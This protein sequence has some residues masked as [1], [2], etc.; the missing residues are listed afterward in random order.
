MALPLFQNTVLKKYYKN[1]DDYLILEKWIL[2][3]KHF[4]NPDIQKN[5]KKA[6]EEQYQEG[7]LRDLF[8]NILGY[9]LNPAIDFNLTTEHKN[10]RNGRK[11]D[12]AIIIDTKIIGVI[13]LKGTNVT[14]LDKIENQA[15][16]YKNNQED[17][18]YVI[19]SNFQKIRLYIDDAV[20]YIEFDLFNINDE[21]F[22]TLYLCLA[23]SNIEAEIPKK[24]KEESLSQDDIITQKLY[25][26]YTN[27]KNELYQNL[28]KLNPTFDKLELF[29]KSQKLL[30]RFLFM[31]F[32]EDRLLIAPN[33][34]RNIISQWET[35][36][37]WN[38]NQPLYEMFKL[39]F[40]FLNTGI[41]NKSMNVFGY[42]G[43]LF[44]TDTTLNKIKIDD[45]IL[46]KHILK[47]ANY[48][49]A[50]E[51]DV[52]ILGHIFE[53]SLNELDEIKAQIE[54][55][56]F[57]KNQTKRKKDGVFYTPQYITRYIIENT[58]GKYCQIQ[59][60]NYEII[61]QN[62]SMDINHTATQKKNLL[63]KLS[64]YRKW[65]LQITIIDPA[66]GSGA[67]LNEAF[68]FLIAEHI[69]IDELKANL[70]K[71]DL[72]LTDVE[73][74]ILENNLF[75]V[76]INEES[77]D[78]AKLSLWLRTAQ[79]NRKLND[80]SNNIK[81]GNSLIDDKKIA[82]EKAFDWQKEFE[83]VFQ[84][85]GFDIVIGNPPYVSSNDTIYTKYETQKCGDLYAF[86]F[87]KGLNIQ[88]ENG[89]L[90]YITPSLFVK[91]MKYESLRNYLLNNTR[92]IEINN[93]GDKVFEEVQM[94][95]TI[96][97]IKKEKK[98]HQ[99]W[100]DFIPNISIISKLNQN[101]FSLGEIAKIMRGIEIGK[102]K[103]FEEKKTIQFLTGEN[104][105][106][107][108]I[109]HFS[110]IDN[111]T[112]EAFKKD[113]Y[114]FKE[115]R[116][117]IR[118]TGNRLTSI[119]LND[120]ITLQN[121]SLYAIKI[122]NNK[123]FSPLYIL[124]I[125]N[126]KVMQLYYKIKFA[127][128]TNIFPK[129]RIGQVKELPIKKIDF[130]KQIPFI[131]K[132]NLMIDLHQKIFLERN[133]FLATLQE[134]TKIKEISKKLFYFNTLTFEDFKNELKKQKAVFSLGKV[135]NQWREYF[136]TI[137]EKVNE[138]ETKISTTDNEIDEMVF[139]LY[140]LTKEEKTQF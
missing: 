22:K 34:T 128:E 97:I 62:Y 70:F 17:C 131:E 41:Q 19:T 58:I 36:K 54:N 135:T 49:F 115:E 109:S 105:V 64:T 95:T 114:Y 85:G 2:Y 72:E 101:S 112:F 125:L 88:K 29:I 122:Q 31:F 3:K 96:T 60:Q 55:K 133:N 42:N 82:A 37:V 139:D 56:V 123:E 140:G 134:E 81:C 46:V 132:A 13:E 74:T 33:T 40:G 5:I 120:D 10:S 61:D 94:P 106:R 11:A 57:E 47:I 9:K 138:I 26:D 129:I 99:N 91:G 20:K 52:N 137:K 32:A 53:N 28:L 98:Y 68:N 24:I 73:N 12:G 30:D 15:F 35:M 104:I 14:D 27:F 63:E 67:F 118:E 16:S 92:I 44:R 78:I 121:R 83:K 80:L 1:Q 23:Y 119:Y 50:S 8:V 126:S 39:Y 38:N 103:V 7:F 6:K 45:A 117:L 59:K 93:K 127:T 136:T 4:L 25:Q 75:G 43:G 90:G 21:Q 51:I 71:T 79:P 48:D 124:T 76:D 113:E 116:I 84:K 66:C 77:V 130:N 107:Y 110:F 69:K 87:E 102:D 111:E 100:N 18:V 108:G 65:L 89:Y 86:F